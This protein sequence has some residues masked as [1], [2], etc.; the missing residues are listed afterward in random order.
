M[1]AGNFISNMFNNTTKHYDSENSLYKLMCEM[2]F[3]NMKKVIEAYFTTSTKH[4]KFTYTGNGVV[5]E[6]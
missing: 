1:I 5:R 6:E 4:A 2:D 3:E